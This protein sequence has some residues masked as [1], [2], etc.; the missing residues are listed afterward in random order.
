MA[1]G[2]SAIPRPSR[3]RCRASLSVDGR[4]LALT[5]RDAPLKF[6]NIPPSSVRDA[7]VPGSN[8][9]IPTIEGIRSAALRG[10]LTRVGRDDAPGL[11]EPEAPS[12]A[13]A[14]R[15]PVPPRVPPFANRPGLVASRGQNACDQSQ[16]RTADQYVG[17]VPNI[18]VRA[19]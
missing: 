2:R 4:R 8:P 3:E 7:E 16:A 14:G 17:R 12:S 9:G 19:P 10:P 6:A 15:F 18:L 1:E 13:V 11:R 5:C